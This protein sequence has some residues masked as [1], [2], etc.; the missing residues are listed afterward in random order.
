MESNL[1]NS[2]TYFRRCSQRS[3]LKS[4][5]VRREILKTMGL[6]GALDPLSH[7]TAERRRPDDSTTG[8]RGAGRAAD[9]LVQRVDI[10]S[11]EFIPMKPLQLYCRSCARGNCEATTKWLF[12]LSYLLSVVSE[13]AGL[14][15]SPRSSRQ[16]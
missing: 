4:W 5:T 9:G 11:G 6:L 13:R 7:A 2:R 1:M 10:A 15:L 12:R 8:A 14:S 16:C 3:V